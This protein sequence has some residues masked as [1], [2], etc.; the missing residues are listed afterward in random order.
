[1]KVTCALTQSQV[2]KLYA[3]V[4]GHM[5]NQGEA[6]DAKQYMTDLFNKIAKNKDV[7]TAAKFLQQVPSLIGTAS[8]RP[9]IEEFEIST[10][11]L[12]PLIKQFK[13]DDNGLINAVT[14]FNPTLNPE[15]KKE[16]VE[17]KANEAFE[18][19]ETSSDSIT[20]DPFN[21]QPYSAL[22]TTFQEFISKDPNKDIETETLD[23]GRRTIYTTL[24][25]IRENANNNTPLKELIYQNTVLKLK[26]IKLSDIN[27]E[28]LDKTTLRLLNRA[29][30]LLGAGKAQA[31]VTTPDKIFLMVITDNVETGNPL[32][33]DEKGNITTKELGGTIVFQFLR[34]VR[35]E[36]S[37]YRV[38]D[39]YGK[40][41]QI[42]DPAILAQKAD[43]SF[44]EAEAR[45]QKEFEELYNFRQKLIKDNTAPL[46][47]IVGVSTGVGSNKPQ[48]LNLSNVTL[49]LEDDNDAI[50]S[51]DLVKSPRAGL[52]KGQAIV[53]IKGEEIKVDRPNLTEDIAKKIAAVLTNKNMTNKQKYSFVAQFLANNA[54][55]ATRKH[56]LQY[57]ENTDTLIYK[58]SPTTFQQGYSEMITVNL[59]APKAADVISKSLMEASGTVGKFYSAKMTYNKELLD[60]NLYQDYDLQTNTLN[61]DYSDYIELLKGLPNTKIFLDVTQESKAFNSY[62]GF[63]I[64]NQFTEQLA[65]AQENTDNLVTDDL[66]ETLSEPEDVAPVLGVRETREKIISVLE[67][68]KQ[69]RGTISKPFGAQSKWHI[70]TP[71]GN[72]IEFYNKEKNITAE[73]IATEVSLNLVPEA[74]FNGKKFTNVIEV[75]AGDKLLGYVRETEDFDAPKTAAPTKTVEEI[76]AEIN[77]T[78]D[79]KNVAKPEDGGA[80]DIFF[81]RKG[82][83]PSDVSE[84]QIADAKTW[85]A[86]SPLN[87]HIGFREVANIVN[88]DAFARFTAYGATLNGNLGMIDLA[89][90]GSMVDVYHEAWHGFSQLYLSRAEKKA[91]YREVQKKL[92]T[93]VDFFEIEEMLAEDFR[94]Y[95][96]T[97]K[98]KANSPKRN[99]LFRKILNFLRELFGK[100]SVTDTADI[101]AVKELFDNLYLGKGLNIYTPSID[102]VM[103]DVLYRNS[104]VVKPGTETDQVLNRQ[105]SNLLKDSM[106]S[107]ISD[108]IDDQVPSKV[109]KSG[110]LSILLDSRNREPLYKLIKI[111][112]QD[113]LNSTTK[114]LEDTEDTKEN[115][116]KKE[117]LEN[118]IRIL[119][120]GLDNYGDTTNGLIKYHVDNSTYDLMRQ[121]YTALEL[122]EEGNLMEPANLEN[123][124]RYGDKKD[125]QKS[126]IELAG[127]ETLYILK[128]LHEGKINKN[129]NK[130]EYQY[131]ELGFKKLADFRTTWNNTV[132]AI[133]GIQDAQEQY[134]KL[135]E[136]SK[137]NAQI[138]QLVDTKIANPENS[139]NQYEFQATSAIW[140]DFSK[141]RIPYIQLTVFK[142]KIG[143]KEVPDGYYGTKMIDIFE[144]STA[145]TDASNDVFNVIRKFQEN[146][147]AST[148]NLY[149]DRIGRDNIPTLNLQKVVDA[150]GINGK[151]DTSN[152]F[153]FARAI[154]FYL[155]D[156]SIIKNTLKKDT[157]TIEQFGLPYIYDIVKRLNDKSKLENTNSTVK[158]V[159]AK[160][161]NDPIQTL[162]DGI[163]ENIIGTTREGQKNKIKEI[164][165]L[166]SKY[167]LEASTGMVL[168]AERNLVSE[169]IENNTISKQVYALNNATKLSD[170]WT[171]DKFQHMSYLDP[172]TNPY[173]KRLATIRT[174]YE[175]SSPEQKRR[176]NRS[177]KLFMDSGTQIEGEDTGL[178]TTSLDVNGK[179]LQEINTMLKDGVQEFMRHASKSS[180]FGAKIE[181]GVIGLPG[182]EGSD[183]HLWIDVKMFTDNTAY[184]Y[185]FKA[186]MLPYMEAEAERIFK[187]RQNKKEYSKYAGYNR[188]LGNGLMAG[189]VFTAFDN[190]LTKSSKEQIYKAIDKAI[191]EKKNF[192]LTEFLRNDNTGLLITVKDNVRTYFKD[193]TKINTG[194]LTNANFISKDLIKKMSDLGV[195]E[196]QIEDKLVETYTYN[197]WVQNFEM[198]VLFYGDMSQYNHDKEELH[199]RNTGST[200]G[201]RGFR[202]DIAARNFVKDFLAKTSYAKKAGMP[203]IAYDGTYNTAIIQDVKRTS[204]YLGQIEKGLRKDYERRYKEAGV[205]NAKAE[206]DIRVEKEI[207]KYKDIEEADGQG[208]ITF[209]AYRTLRYLENNWSNEQEIL[210]QRILRGEEVNAS[211]ITEMFPVYKV[212]NF[213]ALANTKLPVTAMHKFAL[214]PLI[215]S[216]IEGSDLQSLHRQMMEDNIQYVSFQT[217]SKVGSE[218]S[219][220]NEEGEAV[221][222][223]IYEPKSDQKVLKKNIKFTKNT[224]YLENLKNV[225]SVPNKY[226]NKT[227]FSTQLRKLI[228]GGLYRNG[229]IIN[230]NNKAVINAY[231]KAVDNYSKILKL[232]LLHEIGYEENKETGKYTG[233][234]KDF[235]NVVQ[236][237]LERKD[238]PEHLVQM[239][240]L[241]RDNSIKT[242]LSLHLMAD[243]IEAI[244]VALVEKRLIKQKVKGEPLVQVASSMSNGLWD[245]NL[246]K[247]TKA[248]ILK[249][250]GTNNLPFY[251]NDTADGKTLAMKVAIALQGDFVNLL[252]LNHLDGQPIGTR[253]RLNDMIKEDA[254][255]DQN[256]NRKSVTLSAVRIPVQGLNS[257]EFMEVYEFLDPA[258]GNIIIPPTEIVAKSGTDYDVDK[259]TTF[260]PTIDTKGNF[261]KTGITNDELLAKVNRL[262]ATP[263]GSKTATNLIKIQKAALENELISTIKGILELPDNYAGLVRPNDTYLLKDDIAD[264]IENDVVEYNRFQN[265]HKESE[266]IGKKGEKVISP[267]RTLEVS[268]NLHKHEVNMVGKRVLG[269]IAIENALHPVLNSIG[270]SLPATYQNPVFDEGLQRN[271]D[272]K[273]QTNKTRLLLPHNKTTE[274]NVSLSGTDTADGLDNIG[275]LFSQM[276][277]GAVDVEKN[278]WIFFIQGNYEI[279]PM[280]TFLLKAGVPK[281]H[282]IMFVSNPLVREYA[283]QQRIIKGAY[284]KMTGKIDEN[285]PETKTKYEAAVNALE[286]VGIKKA[287]SLVSAKGYYKAAVDATSK[288]GILNDALEFDIKMMSKLVKNPN[289]PEL[290]NHAVAMFLHFLELEKSTRGYTSLK[291]MSNPDTKTSKTLQEI[292]RRNLSI[293]DAKSMS[294]IEEGTVEKM[295]DSILGSFYD[296]KL[297]GD[298]IVPLFP[299]RNNDTVTNY[300]VKTIQ[301]KQNIITRTFG[302]GHDGTRRFITEFK[303]AIP[304]YIYQNYKS[305]FIDE[306]G[307]ITSMPD[308][309]EGF[310]VKEKAGV[311]NGAQIING[312]L[313]ID[314]TRLSNEY[315]KK[316]YLRDNTDAAG[317]TKQGL[318]GFG[319]VEKLFP[320]EST[321]FKYVFERELQRNL[322]SM[323]SLETN[324]DYLK[325]NS[326][327]K[328][329]AQ[330][331]EA[332]IN[333]RA[334]INAF[335]RETIMTLDGQSYTDMV[336]NMVEE[337]SE[338]KNKYP[339]LTQFTIPKVKTGERVLSLNDTKSLKDAQLA[340]IYF[341]NLE[342]LGNE[343]IK[344]VIDPEDNKRI[345]KLF[346]LLP[347][348]M[349]YQHGIGYSKY[350]F[351]RALPYEG[352]IGVMQTASEIFINKQL[353][354]DT[355]AVIFDKLV[356]PGN[357]VF[358]NLLVTPKQYLKPE[359]S[360]V[361]EEDE[362]MSEEE[363]VAMLEKMG[364]KPIGEESTQSST[365]VNPAEFTNH[366]GGA[367][368]GDTFWDMIGREFGVTKHMH[369]KDAGN[370]NLSQKLRNAGIKATVLTKEQMDQARTEVE[371]LLGQSYP[372]T[373]QGNLQVRNYYQ[374]ANA[375]AVYAIAEIT[376]VVDKDAPKNTTDITK[377][378]NSYKHIVKGGT[379]TAVQLGIKLGKPVYVWDLATQSWY[380]WDGNR[381]FEETDTPTLTKNFAGIG[382]R[383]IESYNVQKDGKWL[384]REQYKGKKVEEAA[385]QAIR[386]V[387]V[388]TFKPTQ[389]STS[390]KEGVSELFDSNPELA[391][392]GTPE[393]YSEYLSTIFPNSQVKDIVYHGSGEKIE[394]FKDEFK[395]TQ[396]A[397]IFDTPEYDKLGFFFTTDKNAAD[398]IYAWKFDKQGN[399]VK[400]Q[401][402]N[403]S[404][405]NVLNPQ[406]T[407]FVTD[408]LDAKNIDKTKD[409]Y[410]AE[411]SS[412]DYY[413]ETE[414]ADGFTRELKPYQVI[415]VPKSEQINIL[416]SKK[417]IEGFKNFVTQPPTDNLNAP[418]GLPGIPRTS[419]DCQ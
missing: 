35:K 319:N 398:T 204:E 42:I 122:D 268:Y 274:G 216:V 389:S 251:N 207:S 276:M 120:A 211:D 30:F 57:L 39:I 358:K 172:A 313:Y 340:E 273:K 105:D 142:T 16:L 290:K 195:A 217:G 327:I 90:K 7:D 308:N 291:F 82:E 366:S 331:Y 298:L 191:A 2:E 302:R 69:V 271:V 257:M 387:Y 391:S 277:N 233:N 390:V 159:I 61:D 139:T 115:E 21:Y 413:I 128:S 292:I 102:N 167:G 397:T 289:A 161:K 6:F 406:R 237:E 162:M 75:K 25:A 371:R 37:N 131:N 365:S 403:P 173:T 337:F 255:L 169:F 33:F 265:M 4:Y 228:L 190:V 250:M 254:W 316:L 50:R 208:F 126:L 94:E 338:L 72:I 187:F 26:P 263:E 323:K 147:K 335:N 414:T 400:T 9:S 160:F 266:R 399:G 127:K 132:R 306:N 404:I 275:D 349:M 185:G 321:Y 153:A 168:N 1:M 395:A 152:S 196:N 325:I 317:Y 418:D 46:I 125:G 193:Q 48:S 312:T 212:Q 59:D 214:A 382:S 201:G 202:T 394:E 68:G 360:V 407:K 97:G 304:N 36:G 101:K 315:S 224:I 396:N 377:S 393:Q 343:D 378:V 60:A 81:Y 55:P 87:K 272:S 34:E 282:A 54:S 229:K 92:G 24:S 52:E 14:Y 294:T 368:G 10:D 297:I 345:S 299:L 43:I 240:G 332:Y 287:G 38:T 96:R 226:K 221:A 141:S 85:W 145:V 76:E 40:S 118:R 415:I 293:E 264:K 310:P 408:L 110:T 355:L 77:E 140:Q 210:F 84:E 74:E 261:V 225:T 307:N 130:I 138:K 247:G 5:L 352:F 234:L 402:L 239:V 114:Q 66:F 45:Q 23:Q 32:F 238:V 375:D 11:M 322:Y 258:A 31:N 218:T 339:I 71:K 176:A 242:D 372:D 373:L 341:Q 367:Y 183:G 314:K 123:T 350:G 285:F 65:K 20:V 412:E 280:I 197:S 179:F 129:T 22:S 199:K 116:F 363:A 170:L 227:V 283:K 248:D 135:V 344:K 166:Q 205:K 56:D 281:E 103:F 243:E 51:L 19:K 136:E 29:G 99:S 133:G 219:T 213:G 330:S 200:S 156:I 328:D 100:G 181:G 286:T 381:W 83:L 220:V 64:P 41:D 163:P 27:P 134:D 15:V 267:T 44:E 182:K 164:A 206:I 189:E 62:M 79:P 295:M 63:A 108:I 222:D 353:N 230:S 300:I 124:E 288:S 73:D 362:F 137:T 89:A 260:M 385:K 155:D 186:H 374:V 121:K 305:N 270:A 53:T 70:T 252:K 143:E 175:L 146:F 245:N 151:L 347:Q 80:A 278:P 324:K 284:A 192:N 119:K 144:Y 246:K 104:G 405:I 379:N 351:T 336:L 342:D 384:P 28:L 8:F 148:T 13:K 416:G 198:A 244:L 241:N 215:P 392:I 109:I 174:L 67:S 188:D 180:S 364:I 178:N 149:V 320:N 236:R 88:S 235:L 383:D 376:Q 301:L 354:E 296:N 232:E 279:A 231:E 86:N 370:A 158:T 329:P 348:M 58:Y 106:D 98:V 346:A 361:K 113:K 17:K 259:L 357:K 150:F 117:L 209:D 249:F 93:K 171:T 12:R 165:T 49:I 91:L 386:D 107:I 184:E 256:D 203:T 3:N 157:K 334:L 223:E 401:N 359:P 253:A 78:L 326:I 111:K 262:A 333:Q 356:E 303:N 318:R 410:I 194:L 409:G 309:F 95:V 411:E 269:L 417:D 419:T 18:I 388:N 154:G 47:D 380:K 112:L 369:Y 177:L 311:K